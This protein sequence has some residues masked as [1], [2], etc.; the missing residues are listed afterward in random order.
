[1]YLYDTSMCSMYKILCIYMIHLYDL[2]INEKFL[3]RARHELMGLPW[4]KPGPTHLMASAP[5][6]G[7]PNSPRASLTPHDG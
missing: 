7:N 2:C 3:A 1:M 4:F 6:L 5:G